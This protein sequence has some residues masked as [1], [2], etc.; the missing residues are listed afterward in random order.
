MYPYLRYFWEG[1]SDQDW[2]EPERRLYDCELVYVSTGQV[3]V[4]L[5]GSQHLLEIGDLVI[6]PPDLRHESW[7]VEA[8]A[9]RHCFHFDWN[10]DSLDVQSPLM[11]F[12]G[13]TYHGQL[14]HAVPA[15]FARFLPLIVR[16]QE[17]PEIRQ[18]MPT[19]LDAVRKGEPMGE[20]LLWPVLRRLIDVQGIGQTAM[21]QARTEQPIFAIKHLIDTQYALPL[22]YDDFCREAQ[23]SQSHLCTTFRHL[24]GCPPTQYL[25]RVRLQHARRLLVGTRMTIPEVAAAIGIPDSSYFARCFRKEFSIPPSQVTRLE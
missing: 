11:C 23:L 7:I 15:H 8:P 19:I 10:H 2:I 4:V 20:L 9:M 3:M 21:R 5:E 13:E 6:I 17:L 24:V 18:L 16:G 1:S 25:T 14:I 22:T 12:T